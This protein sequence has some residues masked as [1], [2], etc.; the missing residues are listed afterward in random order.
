MLYRVAL[1]ASLISTAFAENRVLQ[2]QTASTQQSFNEI[3]TVIRSITE[4]PEVMVNPEQKSLTL[5]GTPDQMAAASWIFQQLEHKAT[6]NLQ[7][8]IEGPGDDVIGVFYMPKVTAVRQLQ[9]AATVARSTGHWRKLFVYSGNNAAVVRGTAA[10]IAM[11]E[12]IFSELNQPANPIYHAPASGDDFTR[13]FYLSKARTSN[14]V[15]E[16]ATVTRSIG[17][18]ERLFIY[19]PTNAVVVRGKA[20]DIALA[21]WLFAALDGP[22]NRPGTDYKMPATSESIRILYLTPQESV[23]RLQE[24]AMNIRKTA[25]IPRLFT[26]SESRAI[27]TRGTPEQIAKAERLLAERTR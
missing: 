12:W 16:L 8:K 1:A 5:S 19:S 18:I 21:E 4:V 6:G 2:F 10:D 3:A 22:T 7:H 23:Q 9:E 26:Y 14:Q 13:V 27:I 20:S 15:Q 24:M 11:A 25:Q 17:E